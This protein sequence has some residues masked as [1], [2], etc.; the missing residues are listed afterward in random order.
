[1]SKTVTISCDVTDIIHGGKVE[2]NKDMPMVFL[3][4]TTE[5]RSTK[6]YLTTEKIDICELCLQHMID[7]RELLTGEGSQGYNKYWFASQEED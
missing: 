3:T 5:G 1:M 6:P 4:E 7:T 2:T